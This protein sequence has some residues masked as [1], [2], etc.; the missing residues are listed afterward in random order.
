MAHKHKR[1]I[2]INFSNIHSINN[3]KVTKICVL[4]TTTTRANAQFAQIFKIL[5]NGWS[6]LTVIM[7]DIME[8]LRLKLKCKYCWRMFQWCNIIIYMITTTNNN[9]QQCNREFQSV[10]TSAHMYYDVVYK[11]TLEYSTQVRATSTVNG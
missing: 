4:S 7:P 2:Y 5:W 3:K 11:H 8:L 9:M 6:V 10:F 1:E